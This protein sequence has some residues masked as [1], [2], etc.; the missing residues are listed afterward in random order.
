[1]SPGDQYRIK[2]AEFYGSQDQPDRQLYR[3]NTRPW[4]RAIRGWP[5]KRAKTLGD[6][7]IEARS[8][9]RLPNRSGHET[10]RLH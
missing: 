2:A 10:P 6:A 3:C 8:G 7:R 5:S 9:A 4:R 1:M